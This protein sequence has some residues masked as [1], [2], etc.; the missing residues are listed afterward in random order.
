MAKHRANLLP[1]ADRAE[2]EAT[3]GKII[4]LFIDAK[5]EA[6]ADELIQRYHRAWAVVAHEQRRRPWIAAGR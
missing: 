3:Y 6:K 5:L 1:A 2:L 4:G